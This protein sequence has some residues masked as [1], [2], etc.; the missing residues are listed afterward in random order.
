MLDHL[1]RCA[2]GRASGGYP[3]PDPDFVLD[4][5]L[6]VLRGLRSVAALW[7]ADI[8][9]DRRRPSFARSIATSARKPLDSRGM[10]VP[11]PTCNFNISN[12]RLPG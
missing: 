12:R 2:A 11:R 5:R 10:N 7:R 6:A 1:V 9:H 4:G 8:D 3:E